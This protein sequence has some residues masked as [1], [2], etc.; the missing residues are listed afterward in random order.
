MEEI[1]INQLIIRCA[2]FF[3]S[4]GYSEETIK[5][6][7]RS[8]K[9]GIIPFMENQEEIVYDINVGKKYLSTCQGSIFG[10]DWRRK[11]LSIK[12]LND[13]LTLG[14][15]RKRR[16]SRVQHPLYGVI[17]HEMKRYLIHLANLRRSKH[18]LILYRRYLSEFLI[19]LSDQGVTSLEDI[20]EYHIISMV[21]ARTCTHKIV[22]SLRGLF[23]YWSKQGLVDVRFDQFFDSYRPRK[24]E[25][26]PSF[27]ATEEITK[28]EMSIS[29]SSLTGK[30]DYAM[31][32]LASRL[33]LRSSDIASLKLSNIDW[34]N[35]LINLTMVKTKKKIELPLLADVGNAIIDYLQYSRPN[36]L[37]KNIF[38]RTRAPY[39]AMASESVSSAISSAICRSGINV[40]NKHHGPHSLR[41]SLA[42]N[43]LKA[44][45]NMP[46]IS[47]T[48]G[49]QDTQTTMIY[50]NID[51]ESLLKCTLS[52]PLVPTAFYEQKG[53]IF[54]E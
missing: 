28:V 47:E 53:G 54:Y 17:G 39:T 22:S 10:D 29:R 33:G 41:H 26:I 48:L 43:M 16:F 8:W 38:L 3:Q 51:I 30:R 6:Y 4:Q 40:N 52:I 27:Y 19:Y 49:H 31:L 34:N 9:F 24:K 37:L 13:M 21:T 11:V 15:I 46:V 45:V 50:L 7:Q 35:N 25:R 20:S 12:V 18:T 44:G 32:L 36:S 23:R 42:S 2:T 14:Y 1:T 5:A